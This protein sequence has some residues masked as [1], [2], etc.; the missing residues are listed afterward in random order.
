MLSSAIPIALPLPTLLQSLPLDPGVKPNPPGL[1]PRACPRDH[2]RRKARE[3]VAAKH[4]WNTEEIPKNNSTGRALTPPND[5][6]MTETRSTALCFIK[7][8]LTVLAVTYEWIVRFRVTVSEE[9]GWARHACRHKI[10]S[11]F[12]TGGFAEKSSPYPFSF[13]PETAIARKGL[14]AERIHKGP[15]LPRNTR[16]GIAIGDWRCCEH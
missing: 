14:A 9:K 7:P 8:V 13:L 5:M 10:T 4:S 3:C 6:A 2:A 15:K 1:I 16:E 12:L 11:Y